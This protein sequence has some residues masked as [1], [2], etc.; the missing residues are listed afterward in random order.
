MDVRSFNHLIGELYMWS[1][2]NY[3]NYRQ[4]NDICG[5]MFLLT[6]QTSLLA[7]S[8]SVTKTA[9]AMSSVPLQSI[10]SLN[11]VDL[12]QWLVALLLFLQYKNE[13][14]HANLSVQKHFS[15]F[16]ACGMVCTCVHTSTNQNKRKRGLRSPRFVNMTKS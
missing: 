4:V 13:L 15:F 5:Y 11:Y 3:L 10:N 2:L 9:M 7:S 14:L 6:A 12:V 1:Y 8:T 16:S